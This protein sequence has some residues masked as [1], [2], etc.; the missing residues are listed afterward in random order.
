MSA[1]PQFFLQPAEWLVLDIESGDA[2]E[3]AVNAAVEAWTPPKNVKDADKLEARR[4]EAEAKRRERAALLDASP[5]ICVA[6]Q[7]PRESVVFDGMGAASGVDGWTTM[8]STDER[9]MLETL[10]V[11]LDRMTDAGTILAGH[12]IRDFDLPK[13]RNAYLRHRLRLPAILAPKIKDGDIVAQVV[14]TAGLFKAFSMEHRNDFCPG[15]DTV[16]RTL[17][18]PRPKMVISGA[19]VPKYHKKGLFS[20]ILIYCCI[21]VACTSQAYLLMT[22]QSVDL[23]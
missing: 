17:G 18:I 22:G 15:L 14:D 10:R 5:I 16:A 12:N 2:P 19:D 7:T 21:D 3:D 4:I 13:L 23:K 9:G 8:H 1:V 20:E 11:W 6:I